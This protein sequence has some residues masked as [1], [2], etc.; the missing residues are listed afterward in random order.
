MTWSER[1]RV[2]WG[3][4][5]FLAVEAAAALVSF[6]FVFVGLVI[7]ATL[8]L[9]VGWLALPWYLRALRWWAASARQRAG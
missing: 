1:L 2:R 6:A 4:V 3:A 5:R 8:M 9:I 7:A